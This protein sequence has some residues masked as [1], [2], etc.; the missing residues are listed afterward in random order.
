[1][2]VSTKYARILTAHYLTPREAWI[3]LG[4]AT[5]ADQAADTCAPLI[6]W[7]RTA[8]TVRADN[9]ASV[10][11]RIA[12]T[13]PIVDADLL[14]HRLELMHQDLPSRFLPPANNQG[15]GPSSRYGCVHVP[16]RKYGHSH[17]TQQNALGRQRDIYE[18]TTH[19]RGCYCR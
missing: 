10:V 14:A 4:G 9:Q 19:R 7:L 17:A 13:V 2:Y 16:Q 8:C 11:Q 15:G 5:Y 1:M 18:T 3:R 6:N 12:P